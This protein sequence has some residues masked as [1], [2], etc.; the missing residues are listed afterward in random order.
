MQR[1]RRWTPTRVVLQDTRASPNIVWKRTY[2]EEVR[3]HWTPTGSGPM[4]I[5]YNTIHHRPASGLSFSTAW[6]LLSGS[7]KSISLCHINLVSHHI[8]QKFSRYLENSTKNM[9]PTHRNILF[10]G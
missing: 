1:E 10:N 5:Q 3:V 9:I 2:S 7:I 4:D 6:S 8:K